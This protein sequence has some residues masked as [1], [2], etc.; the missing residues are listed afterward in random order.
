MSLLKEAKATKIVVP[1]EENPIVKKI[2]ANRPMQRLALPELNYFLDEKQVKAVPFHKTF[3]EYHMKPWLL[4][5]TSGSTGIPKI[6]TLRHGYAT[7]IDAYQRFER[8]SEIAQR[9]GN[10]RVLNPFPPFHMSG[11]MWSTAIIIFIDSTIVLPPTAP[12]TADVINSVHEYGAV[13]YSNLPPSI[14]SGLAKNETYL[15]NLGRLKGLTFAG[16]PLSK[17][18]G[19]LVCKSVPLNTSYGSTE[20]GAPPLL[21]KD[22]AHW[23]YFKFD[24]HG[25]GIEFREDDGGFR[26]MVIVRDRKLDLMQAI[27]V[28]FPDLQEY[29]T[30][31]LFS[32][33]PQEKDL[34]KYEGRLDDIIVFSNGEKLNP[35]T[36]EGVVT[37]CPEVTGAL[38]VGQGKFQSAILIEA[39]DP[40]AD[41]QA[42]QR[43]TDAIWP[44]IRRANK[45]CV[46]NG[47]VVREL[48][49]YTIPSKPLPRAGKG[50]IQRQR[51]VALYQREIDETYERLNSNKQQDTLR[52]KLSS[53]N[54]TKRVLHEYIANETDVG[55]IALHQDLFRHGMDSLQ[56]LSLVRIIN[57]SLEDGKIEPEQVYQNPTIEQVA[58]V[59]HAGGRR[60]P[61]DFDEDD[62]DAWIQMENIWRAA[63]RALPEQRPAFSKKRS[64]FG[65]VSKH[66][67][68]EKVRS[69]HA[70]FRNGAVRP[71]NP[72]R[73]RAP[74][75]FENASLDTY[76][77]ND[78]AA[79]DK[80]FLISMVPPDG[81]TTA[82]L[83][84]LASFLI[85]VNNWGLVNSFGVYQAYYERTLLPS[86]SSTTI[87][88]IGTLQ[89]ALLLL[90]GVIS[91]P[92][93]DMGFFRLI[94]VSAGL[95]LVFAL[96]MLSLATSYYQVLLSQGL[97]L[98]ICGGLLYI[99]SVALIPLYF[100]DRRGLALGLATSGA[101]VGG[102]VYPIVFRRLL[103]E[104]GFAWATRVI[105]FIALAT[106]AV[107]AVI[108][109]PLNQMKKPVRQLFEVS[110]VKEV[111]LLAFMVS[112]FLLFCAFLIPF[113]L[114]PTFAETALGTS[115]DT[116]FYLLAVINA[117]QFFG[118]TI[119][120]AM[121]DYG[122]G[123]AMLFG[124]EAIAGILGLAWIAVHNLGGFVV[125]L[126]FYGFASGMMATLPAVVL[127]Y[128]CPSLAVI[129]TRL[130]MV[131]ACAGVGAL[132]GAPIATAAAS[133]SGGYLGA[134][135][136][137]GLCCFVAAICYI[138]V[139]YA[140]RRQ[141]RAID[142]P[143]RARRELG[144]T[145]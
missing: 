94:L 145:G 47:R 134:Q 39:K 24:I 22:P 135:L 118:R 66:A 36:M 77:D 116:A 21:P 72:D 19:D 84:V 59:L 43:L 75:M 58:A 45:S 6:I 119:P 4:L 49:L 80:A 70:D 48:I 132:I 109:Q 10:L 53:V 63:T 38:I 95:T 57:D 54:S 104:I 76:D 17:D 25:S 23:S 90:I 27:F 82:W 98:G 112:A 8:G 67:I 92:L 110:A 99:P 126:I 29:H 123:E 16:G 127:P 88:W 101:S 11:I 12:L 115:E 85:N 71:G 107:A 15:Q 55:D 114:T 35:V 44:F 33:H 41:A 141:R 133:A 81:G 103:D 130:G 91:G 50:T 56:L 143:K 26:E 52:L 100:K 46:A 140:A 30:K 96:M 137:M 3:D 102:V 124:A 20:M 138:P 128:I 13:E 120:A 78:D 34:W 31:D 62:I 121:S 60:E 64:S 28:T 61:K 73:S 106:L 113:F 129:G 14:V 65:R 40:P 69:S 108:V 87:S 83:Q 125:F 9:S 79:N 111:P 32:K 139:G 2:L 68:S 18:I 1:S 142:A 122:A 42:A 86:H 7:T 74:K 97:L 105:A 131:Y 144:L 51:S 136:W 89:G 37:A 93:F 117:A 5:H